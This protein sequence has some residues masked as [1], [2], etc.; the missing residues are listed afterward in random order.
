LLSGRDILGT[1]KVR[2]LSAK[3]DHMKLAPD[4]LVDL[5]LKHLEMLQ[6]LVARMSGYGANFKSYCITVTTAVCGFAIT[7]QRPAVVL[8]A[9]LPI[10]TF[11]LVDAQY[12]RIERRFRMLYERQRKEDWG[13]FPEFAIDLKSAPSTSYWAALG[14]WSV[15]AF[16]APLAIGALV[17]SL[18]VRYGY[19]NL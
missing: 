18:A 2:V 8:L 7:L 4:K 15:I 16:Y 1:K 9:L 19:G 6:S 17:V 13:S 12:L 5:R 10:I 3:K 11:A 14:S